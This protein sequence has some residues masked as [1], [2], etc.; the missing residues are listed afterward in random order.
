MRSAMVVVRTVCQTQLIESSKEIEAR[1][2]KL[3]AWI[4]YGRHAS[5]CRHPASRTRN[6]GA[7]EAGRKNIT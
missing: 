6:Q 3:E 2:M 5:R 1:K 7:S 4:R